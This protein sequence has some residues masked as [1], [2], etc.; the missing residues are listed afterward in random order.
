MSRLR[1]MIAPIG[2]LAPHI[3]RAANMHGAFQR[4]RQEL[5][6]VNALLDGVPLGMMVVDDD[7]LKV[8]NR[9]ARKLLGEGDVM[10]LQNGPPF[11][12]PAGAP[13]PTCVTQCTRLLNGADQ[14]PIGLA[15]PMTMLSRCGPC[16]CR[17]HPA[18]ADMLGAPSRSGSA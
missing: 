15:L 10:R 13:M 5:A 2:R 17:L 4:C 1:R 11:T 8:A 7:E 9:A 16:N 14:P 18:S 12:A 3:T 6:A